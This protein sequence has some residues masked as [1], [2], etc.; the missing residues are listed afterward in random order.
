MQKKEGFEYRIN[1]WVD[2]QNDFG[3]LI[4]TRFSGI[5]RQADKDNWELLALE[6][7]E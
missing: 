5:V 6:F 4:R 1:S 2:S 3:A 7:A